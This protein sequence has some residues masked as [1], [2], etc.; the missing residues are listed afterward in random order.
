MSSPRKPARI[1][2]EDGTVLRGRSFGA[3]GTSVGELVFNTAMTGYQEVLT[4]PSYRGQVVLFTYPHIGNYGISPEDDESARPWLSGILC[5]EASRVTSSHRAGTGLPAYLAEQGV[6]G[7]E[8]FDTRALV[9]RVREGGELKVL[10]TTDDE[11]SDGSLVEELRQAPGLLGRDLVAEVTGAEARPWTRGYEGRFSPDLDGAP[12]DAARVPIVAIDCGIKRNILRSLHEIGF[13]V[14]VVPATTGAD[15][16]LALGPRGLFL[17]NGPGDPAAVPYVVDTVRRLAVDRELPTFGICLGHQ[18]LAQVLGGRTY[19]MR[20][21][22]HGSNH[23]V[24]ELATGEIAITSQNH[25]FAVDRDSLP[26][27]VEVTHVN[28]NDGTVEGLRHATLP[29]WSVQ[30]HPEAAPGPHDALGLF[31]RWRSQFA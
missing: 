27:G 18:I 31:V 8:G 6:L 28:L 3:E 17:S 12:A 22:H 21:G 2:L 5:R 25:S 16:I 30:Y 11:R 14:Q 26:S 7:I 15:E 19:K 29:I 10:L 23:P 13:A 24:Q 1:V 4:D 9:R 20:F